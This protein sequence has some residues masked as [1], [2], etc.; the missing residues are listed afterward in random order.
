MYVEQLNEQM[1]IKRDGRKASFDLIKIRNAVEASMKAINLED[2]T[3]LEEILLEVVSEL[4]NK[5][6]MTIDEIQH[7]VEN[8]LMK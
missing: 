5:A 6:D 2:E 1:V 3:F 8:T 7:C 4:P